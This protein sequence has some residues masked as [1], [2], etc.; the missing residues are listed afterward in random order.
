MDDSK[1]Q[2]TAKKRWPP[3]AGKG[4]KAGVPNKVTREFRETV[5]QLLDKNADNVSVWLEQ[6]ATGGVDPGKA[7]PA[8]ALQ[9]LA[10]LAEYAAPKLAR[11]E[12]VGDPDNPVQTV[13]R[14]ELVPMTEGK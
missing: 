2:E 1:V 12:H 9:I 14:V 3:N 8:K 11:T 6:V 5:R 7:D 13:T 10:Q 4:R